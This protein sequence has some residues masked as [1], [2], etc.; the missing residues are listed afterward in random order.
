[1]TSSANTGTVRLHRVLR[2]SPEK[3]YRA[4]I[5]PDAMAKWLPPLKLKKPNPILAEPYAFDELLRVVATTEQ[6]WFGT[7]ELPL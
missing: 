7:V 1:M 2:A 6:Y 4:F 5:D 3:V